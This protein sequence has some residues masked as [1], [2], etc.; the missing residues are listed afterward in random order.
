MSFFREKKLLIGGATLGEVW[1]LGLCCEMCK[2]LVGVSGSL[3]ALSWGLFPEVTAGEGVERMIN[4]AA[5]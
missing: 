5:F 3:E 1:P 2:Q 4:L